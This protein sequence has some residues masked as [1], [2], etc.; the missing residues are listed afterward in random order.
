[1]SYVED[2]L[3]LNEK[4][5]FSAKISPAIYLRPVFAFFIF[6]L[7]FFKAIQQM[8]SNSQL[9]QIFGSLVFLGSIA[10][11]LITVFLNIEAIVIKRTSEFAVTSRRV[12]SKTGFIRRNTTELLLTKIESVGV[13][14]NILGR[15]LN[16]G[17]IKIHG[18]GGTHQ[19]VS[20]ITDP[21]LTR[22][23]M[24]KVLERLHSQ[25]NRKPN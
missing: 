21:V 6:V 15:I 1:M 16:F 3:L 5:L 9:N 8:N 18:T 19:R 14:Q 22:N 20:P 7:L 12:I 13:S 23:K 11:F 17:T 10:C 2:N 25:S 4:V 24:N